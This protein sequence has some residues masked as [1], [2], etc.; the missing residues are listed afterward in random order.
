MHSPEMNLNVCPISEHH[1][2]ENVA[3]LNSI[4]MVIV[5]LLGLVWWPLWVLAL[6]SFAVK[7]INIRF[8]VL[9]RM[10]KFLLVKFGIGP[11]P[12]DAAPK[13]FSA[14]MGFFMTLLLLILFFLKMTTLVYVVL[15]IMILLMLANA[16]FKYCVG[17]KIYAIL[18][19]M[20]IMGPK[21]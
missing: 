19:S 13:R 2:D 3:R 10:N 16:L 17:C 21:K 9:A 6:I 12:I 20:G 11:E 15:G 14:L 8:C 5:L 7:Y 18:F 4:E 1:V